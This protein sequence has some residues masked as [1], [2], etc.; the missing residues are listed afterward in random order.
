MLALTPRKLYKA[1]AV[2]ATVQ[3]SKLAMPRAH[4]ALSINRGKQCALLR[5]SL[6]Q[7]P[8]DTRLSD[9]AVRLKHTTT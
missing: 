5:G 9:A 3:H 2:Q 8:Q 4:M 6:T 1:A 7:S